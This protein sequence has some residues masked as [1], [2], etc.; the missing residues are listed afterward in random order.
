MEP[1][2]KVKESDPDSS[3][4]LTTQLHYGDATLIDK[5]IRA[6]ADQIRHRTEPIITKGSFGTTLKVTVDGT[7]YYVKYIQRQFRY[8]TREQHG[9][10][11]RER[12]MFKTISDNKYLNQQVDR[13]KREIMINFDLTASLP[14]VVSHIVGASLETYRIY[15][16]YLEAYLIFED[17]PG[18]DF[19]LFYVQNYNAGTLTQD[20]L[21]TVFDCIEA[22]IHALHDAGYVHQD[23]KPENIFIVTDPAGNPVDC[24]LIDLDSVAVQGTTWDHFGTQR[25][26]RPKYYEEQQAI[27]KGL[28]QP[29]LK[30]SRSQN[31]Y[32]LKKM[33]KEITM[34]GFNANPIS[35]VMSRRSYHS[36]N[37]GRANRG[38]GRS[39]G[40]TRKL[41]QL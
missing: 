5:C 32:A 21:N 3:R 4:G 9:T 39:R 1:T 16:D 38:S 12:K 8:K 11:M 14:S 10:H 20:K 34:A 18:M 15:L 7:S 31:L 33:K 19:D 13:V 2:Q 36:S 17:L 25:Y 29:T 24:R 22:K 6:Y 26:M 41:R 40:G 23:V 28:T 35:N 27:K 30:V 37:A